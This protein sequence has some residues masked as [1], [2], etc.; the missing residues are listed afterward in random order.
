MLVPKIKILLSLKFYLFLLRNKPMPIHCLSIIQTLIILKSTM[1][2]ICRLLINSAIWGQ[3]YRVIVK[4][5][6]MLNRESKRPVVPLGLWE[7]VYS[8]LQTFHLQQK[9][10]VYEGLILATLLYGS[11]H[12]C[13]TEIISRK[14]WVF[15]ARC[16]RTI[17]RVNLRHVRS[18]R[19]STDECYATSTTL[20]GSRYQNAFWSFAQ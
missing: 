7:T 17:Y 14:L 2:R 8:L 18:H 12:W 1:Y 20:V 19:I 13:L 4:I 3:F 6:W 11:E 9:K 16:V 5:H 10:Y 15:H